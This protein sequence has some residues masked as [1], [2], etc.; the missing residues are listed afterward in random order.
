MSLLRQLPQG[1]PRASKGEL[2]LTERAGGQG[3]GASGTSISDAQ[4]YHQ[5]LRCFEFPLDF[6]WPSDGSEVLLWVI[7]GTQR[8]NK[9]TISTEDVYTWPAW[10]P[11]GHLKVGRGY[12][13]S[14]SPNHHW[15]YNPA[16]PNV[17][18]TLQKSCF[19]EI[20]GVLYM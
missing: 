16:D 6:F 12:R 4:H 20:H 7:R 9:R 18:R 11:L 15:R 1:R 10:M 3:L 13:T 17:M 14:H 19:S 5:S 8:F 2:A